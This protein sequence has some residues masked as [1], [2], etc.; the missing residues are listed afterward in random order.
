M[1]N[2]VI[3]SPLEHPDHSEVVCIKKAADL[4]LARFLGRGEQA[5]TGIVHQHVQPAE[6][7]IGLMNCLSHLRG[8]GDV[9]GER[10]R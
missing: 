5:R 6:V 1:G 2:A 4:L 8:V 3:P 10:Q 9:E 7:R